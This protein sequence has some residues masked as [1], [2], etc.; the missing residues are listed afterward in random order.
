MDP[1]KEAFAR[2]KQDISELKEEIRLL[3]LEIHEIKQAVKNP[4]DSK[5]TQAQPQ[6][7]DKPTDQHINQQMPSS[8]QADAPTNPTHNSPESNNPTDNYPLYTLKTPNTAIS[9]GNRGVPTDRQTNQQTDQ[10]TTNSLF[11]EEKSPTDSFHNVSQLIDS[12]DSLKKQVR[13]KFKKLTNQEMIVFSTIYQLEEQGLIVDYSLVSQKLNLSESSIRDYTQ[14]IIKKGI[15]LRKSKE[16]NKKI[17]LSVSSDLKKIASL[18][19][20]MQ[21][22]EI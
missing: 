9:T 10:H 11:Y 14:R 19:T 3:R 12:L 5:L 8:F 16:N 7:T 15:P 4:A 17:L 18:A 1:V 6:Q 21:L 20:I 22:R 13:L 2:A